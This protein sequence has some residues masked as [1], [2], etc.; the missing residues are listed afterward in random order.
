MWYLAGQHLPPMPSRLALPGALPTAQAEDL[1]RPLADCLADPWFA[2]LLFDC[3]PDVDLFVKDR[4]ARYV[5][6]SDG[7]VQRAGARSKQDLLGRTTLEVFPPPL[8]RVYYEQDRLVLDQGAAI[9]DRL[10][11]HYYRDGSCWYLTQKFPLHDARGRIIGLAGTSRALEGDGDVGRYPMLARAIE[12]M[13]RN[14]S[15]P[16]RVEELAGVAQLSVA[17]FERAVKRIF[18]VTPVQLL[19][20]TRLEAATEMLAGGHATIAEVAHACGYSDHSAFC[21]QFKATVDMTPTEFRSAVR[22]GQS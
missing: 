6:V 12:H 10:E 8:G 21:R 3:L 16:L 19:A 15:Q 18:R 22:R 1:R 14:F 2:E 5:V 17:R 9:R 7:M 4:Q 20:K 13:R 11:L